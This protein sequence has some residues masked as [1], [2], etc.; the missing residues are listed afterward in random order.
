MNDSTRAF[1]LFLASRNRH[2]ALEIQSILG[3]RFVCRTLRDCPGAPETVEDAGTFE[4]NASKKALELARWLAGPGRPLAGQ[5][6]A[7]AWVLA[8]DSGLEVDALN[9][10]PGVHSARFA[11]MA[12]GRAGNSDDKDNNARLL[13]LLKDVPPEKRT[14][15]FRCVLALV[16]VPSDSAVPSSAVCRADEAEWTL[17]LF[18]GECEGRIGFEPR[19]PGGFGYDPLFT[20]DGFQRTFAELGEEVKNGLSHRARALEALRNHFG[21][22]MPGASGGL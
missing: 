16:A 12:D 15:R 7:P 14:A 1:T 18:R 11:A 3:P 8:D 13:D 2:K 20:P 10:A 5:G 9:G 22:S 21:N 4:G 6:A 17:Q 19:G